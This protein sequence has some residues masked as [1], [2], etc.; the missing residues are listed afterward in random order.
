MKDIRREQQVKNAWLMLIGGGGREVSENG[1]AS[2]GGESG[3]MGCFSGLDGS[4]LSAAP[5]GTNRGSTPEAQ[6]FPRSNDAASSSCSSLSR[7]VLGR[8]SQTPVSTHSSPDCCPPIDQEHAR[9]WPRGLSPRPL[10]AMLLDVGVAT[11]AARM[12]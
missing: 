12:G 4:R 5:F 9:L 2:R 6:H 8:V 7:P 11:G 1:M 10:A 3:V